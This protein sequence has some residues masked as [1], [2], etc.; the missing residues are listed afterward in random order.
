[1][2]NHI[3]W[4]LAAVSV[5][6]ACGACTHGSACDS[7]N[8]C[9]SDWDCIEGQCG[10]A[11]SVP[12]CDNGSCT[13]TCERGPEDGGLNPGDCPPVD[14]FVDCRQGF[15]TDEMV[16][17]GGGKPAELDCSTD[18]DCGD[19][20][21]LRNYGAWL[22]PTPDLDQKLATFKIVEAGMILAAPVESER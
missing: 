8:P 21:A 9:P 18:T 16:C 17:G 6:L 1:M 13:R 10:R 5:L 22:T 20:K 4:M 12:I 2:T 14:H 7:D 19:A 3:L 11:Y 15:G